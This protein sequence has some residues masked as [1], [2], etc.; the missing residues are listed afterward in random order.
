MPRAIGANHANRPNIGLLNPNIRCEIMS[1]T[2]PNNNPP[3]DDLLLNSG[4]F[5]LIAV[6]QSSIGIV[7]NLVPITVK[8]VIV[9]SINNTDRK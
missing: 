1:P 2:K 6:I 4:D 7:N 5:V 9:V 8:S 3:I